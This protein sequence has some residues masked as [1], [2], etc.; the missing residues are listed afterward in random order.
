MTKVQ[1][2][3][4]LLLLVALTAT[5]NIAIDYYKNYPME[6]FS[7]ESNFE[8]K[9]D[10]RTI[11]GIISFVFNGG[12]GKVRGSFNLI[13][14]G[15]K[16]A[17]IDRI[18]DFNYIRSGNSYLLVSKDPYNSEY[19][20]FMR[21]LL[22]DFYLLENSGLQLEIYRQNASGYVFVR[23]DTTIIYCDRDTP[24]SPK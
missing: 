1:L 4:C 3:K 12:K 24:V 5:A 13:K 6:H 2:L 11:S 22:P 21:T 18:F 23:A 20:A 8:T 19:T 17:R 10:D 15:N 16:I 7:C 14:N 9:L